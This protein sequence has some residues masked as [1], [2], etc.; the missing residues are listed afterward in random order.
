MQDDSGW[1]LWARLP[2]VNQRAAVHWL[3]V[4]TVKAVFAAGATPPAASP[5]TGESSCP[6]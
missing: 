2:Q 6:R 4:I 3:A 1:D 5:G